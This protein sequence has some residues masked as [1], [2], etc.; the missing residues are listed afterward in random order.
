[1]ADFPGFPADTRAF[2][3]DLRENNTRDWFAANKSRYESDV[4]APALA[5]VSAMGARLQ[6]L[7]PE[8][9]VD[10]RANGSGALM[11][12]ARDT[13]FSKDKSPYK[14]NIAMMW[15]H[16]SGKKMQHPA[17]GMQ[18][19]PDGADLM[20]GMFHFAK[21]ML[22]AYRGAVADDELG[23][24]LHEAATAVEAAGYPLSGQH[25]KTVPRG[26]DK[27]HPRREWLKFN[28]LH[29]SI[30]GIDWDDVMSPAFIDI[31]FIHFRRMAPILHWLVRV[32]ERF[33]G[34]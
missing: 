28:S 15:W 30:M 20:A 14:T 11:R 13:R 1:M 23:A 3:L 27:D 33:G 2:L 31:C 24:A 29:S 6:S 12:V 10:L 26:F 21:P 32:Q 8:L 16:G 7:D 19:T 9:V 18:I 34:V 22:T 5:W 17:F 4:K 25:Y